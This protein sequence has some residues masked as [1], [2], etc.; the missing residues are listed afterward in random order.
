MRR[1]LTRF[2]FVNPKLITQSK[3]FYPGAANCCPLVHGHVTPCS[4]T[5]SVKSYFIGFINIIYTYMDSST[6]FVFFFRKQ[7]NRVKG[8]L[9]LFEQ[10]LSTRR[11][12]IIKA[13][14]GNIICSN[15]AFI[16]K[17]SINIL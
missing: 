5:Y 8:V 10:G 7:P 9:L 15:F 12:V 11:F 6:F 3:I 14:E 16:S 1:F 4:K 17:V 13:L 2:N